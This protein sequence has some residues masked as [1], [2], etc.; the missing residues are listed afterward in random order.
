MLAEAELYGGSY[1]LART[2][3]DRIRAVTAAGVQ[4]FAKKYLGH[5]QMVV[6]G[7]DPA[8]L[9]QSLFLSL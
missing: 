3:P 9:D 6:I 4:A 1:T 2:M 7:P 5:L 8:K